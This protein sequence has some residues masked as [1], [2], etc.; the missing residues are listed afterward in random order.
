MDL[1][2][3]NMNVKEYLDNLTTEEL[4]HTADEHVEDTGKDDNKWK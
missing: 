2:M 3:L 1:R 4:Q